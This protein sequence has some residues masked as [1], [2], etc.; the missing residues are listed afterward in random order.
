MAVFPQHV[1]AGQRCVAA[2]ID[3]DGRREPAQII[4]IPAKNEKRGFGKVH[5]ARDVL[6]PRGFSG[7][8]ENADGSGIAGEGAVGER[9]DLRDAQ[10]H[11]ARI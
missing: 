11:N 4:S 10:W 7:V 5:L 3:F 2:E 6:H 8:G 1:R 9:V